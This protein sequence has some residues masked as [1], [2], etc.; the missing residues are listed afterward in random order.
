[1]ACDHCEITALVDGERRHVKLLIEG[2][3]QLAWS[4]E[5]NCFLYQCPA[6]R[7]LWE[8]GAYEKAATEI[9]IAEARSAYP[10]AIIRD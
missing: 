3:E 5:R 9:T 6:C 2:I 4:D 7:G 8:S 10:D 1:V